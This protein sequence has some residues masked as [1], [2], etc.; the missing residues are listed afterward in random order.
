M[1][2]N[3]L[4]AQNMRC[5]GQLRLLGLTENSEILGAP[6]AKVQ[7]R[8]LKLV[9]AFY[10]RE[11]KYD[12]CP[13]LIMLVWRPIYNI[14]ISFGLQ[15]LDNIF[16]GMCDW[17]VRLYDTIIPEHSNFWS[18]ASEGIFF[19]PRKREKRRFLQPRFG[20]N[21][22][23]HKKSTAFQTRRERAKC[24]EDL[25]SPKHCGRHSKVRNTHC[26][27]LEAINSWSCSAACQCNPL[28]SVP[29][30]AAGDLI[31]PPISEPIP[32]ILPLNPTNAPSPPD[33]PPLV[34][35]VLNGFVVTLSWS[36]NTLQIRRRQCPWCIPI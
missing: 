36:A 21:N 32:K 17:R 1:R 16:Q 7:V 2:L 15:L 33:D 25:L 6:V 4:I 23:L 20:V 28:R 31:E 8:L 29:L 27:R 14:D 11:G 18:S 12:D 19:L 35:V 9:M 3:V 26:R 5:Q 22:R 24:E 13:G 34:S 30:F 10:G